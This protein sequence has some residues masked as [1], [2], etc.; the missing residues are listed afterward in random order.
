MHARIAHAVAPDQLVL[1]V[2]IDVVLVAKEALVVLLGPARIFVLLPVFRGLLLPLLGRLAGLHCLIVL[3]S[4]AAWAPARWW[5][6]PSGR[7]VRCSPWL[8]DAGRIAQT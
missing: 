3:A 8:R 2:R 1:G 7:R 5:R 6:P 4:C